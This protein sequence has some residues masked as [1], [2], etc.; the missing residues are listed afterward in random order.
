MR[1]LFDF[2]VSF[3]GLVLLFPL[4]LLISMAILIDSPGGVFFRQIRVGKN[5]RLFRLW[6]FRTMRPFSEN[7]GKLTVGNNDPR[8]TRVGA[9]LRKYK[10]DELPQLINVIAGD[11]HLVGPRPEVPEYVATYTPDQLR[12][13]SVKP[14]ITDNASLMYFEEN[15]ILAKS[16]NPEETY[17]KVVL[18]AKLE[19][20]LAYIDN[21][22]FAGDLRII[23]KTLIRIIG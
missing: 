11:M 19:A 4:F 9:F 1:T 12:V 8:I 2:V 3:A 7:T 23:L 16:P 17:R 10:I 6:K 5:R 15:E 14:G 20:N 21:R 13:L 18:P 22:S